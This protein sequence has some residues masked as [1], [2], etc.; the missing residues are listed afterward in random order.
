MVE[1]YVYLNNPLIHRYSVYSM[2]SIQIFDILNGFLKEN[3]SKF[4]GFPP[5][6][7]N[8]KTCY[9][10]TL[11]RQLVSTMGVQMYSKYCLILFLQCIFDMLVVTSAV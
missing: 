6:K 8:R 5:I 9:R 4:G 10:Q 2:L 3:A 11:I 1:G 7:E